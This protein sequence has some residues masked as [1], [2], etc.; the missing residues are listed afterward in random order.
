MAEVANW[1]TL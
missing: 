1:Q